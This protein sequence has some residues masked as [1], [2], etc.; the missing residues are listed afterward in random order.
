MSRRIRT[1]LPYVIIS[2]VITCAALPVLLSANKI[3]LNGDYFLFLAKHEA[4]RESVL[5]LHSFPLRSYWFGGGYPTIA[6]PED[7]ALNPFVLLSISLG[8]V[9]G[10]KLI[11]VA[12]MLVGGIATYEF[13]KSILGYSVYGALFSGLIFG[14]NLFV[15]LRLL[16]GNPNEIYAAF[17]PLCF[18]LLGQACRGE[19]KAIFIL[20]FLFSTMLSDGK[21]TCLMAM[22]YIGVICVISLQPKFSPFGS[23][24]KESSTPRFNSLPLK[25]FVLAAVLTLLVDMVRILPV[26]ELFHYYG[27]RNLIA[28]HPKVYKPASIVAY[29]FGQ[30]CQEAVSWKDRIGF[31]TIG[32]IPMI[33][34]VVALICFWQKM[35]VWVLSLL[36]FAWL[37]MAHHAYID[38]F[39]N[40]WHLPIFE[41]ISRPNK[42]FTFQIVFALAIISG[43]SFTLLHRLKSRAAERIIAI[44]LILTG[45]GFL[46]THVHGISAETYISNPSPLE[47]RP[48][49]GFFNV[50]SNGLKRNRFRPSNSLAYYN[51]RRNI[52]TIDWYNGV[53]LPAHAVPKYFVGLDNRYEKNPNYRGEAY[54][55]NGSDSDL[56]PTSPEFRP[57]SILVPVSVKVPGLVVINQNYHRDWYSDRGRLVDHDGLLGLELSEPGEYT[58]HLNYYP[59]AFYVGLSISFLTILSLFVYRKKIGSMLY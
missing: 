35:F 54:F 49:E 9:K 39:K 43:Q 23:L 22:F 16:D 53:P 32:W 11:G 47:A 12:A 44:A 25:L 6:D 2:V 4:V 55:L 46:Y 42:Y 19:K 10:L 36:F 24:T 52:G 7:P 33:L 34:S 17:L 21:A 30:L 48:P 27:G 8:A 28:S 50:A 58:V 1:L 41:T 59:R 29:T 56:L 26:E 51:L 31:V 18:L 37:A 45:A 57:N 5:R 38:L 14:L 15:P 13:A 40:L 3:L 20:P